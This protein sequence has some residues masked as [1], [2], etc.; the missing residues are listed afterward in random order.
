[1]RVGHHT[2]ILKLR[3]LMNGILF[4]GEENVQNESVSTFTNSELSFEACFDLKPFVYSKYE[5]NL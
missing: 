3:V 5:L 4:Y 1:M 2:E